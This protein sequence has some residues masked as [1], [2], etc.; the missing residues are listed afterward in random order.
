M[1][2]DKE[3]IYRGYKPFKPGPF[4]DECITQG[5]QKAIRDE[6]DDRKYFIT[7]KKWDFS[8]YDKVKELNDCVSYEGDTQLAYKKNG[9]FMNITFLHGWEAEEVEE[10]LDNLFS[11]G[12]FE[13]YD[14][15]YKDD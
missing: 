9:E 11:T 1:M 15:K 12:L 3:L 2:T 5:F 14:M 6:N 7:F 13:K 10:F 8:R 4:D